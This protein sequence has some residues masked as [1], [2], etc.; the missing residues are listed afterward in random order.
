MKDENQRRGFDRTPEILFILKLFGD[1]PANSDHS[2]CQK[3]QAVPA[4]SRLF[5][6]S[7]VLG[8]VPRRLLRTCVQQSNCTMKSIRVV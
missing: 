7:S 4:R 2:P 8:A 6:M 3:T 5:R 1:G